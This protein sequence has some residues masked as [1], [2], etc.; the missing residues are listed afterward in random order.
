MLIYCSLCHMAPAQDF[1]MNHSTNNYSHSKPAPPTCGRS[2]HVSAAYLRMRSAGKDFP[3][4]FPA[5]QCPS[6]SNR[7]VCDYKLVP[8]AN[9]G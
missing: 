9:E 4:E 7:A 1:L 5:L 8:M 3:W 6:R 2:Y